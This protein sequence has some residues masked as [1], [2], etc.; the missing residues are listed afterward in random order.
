MNGLRSPLFL[1]LLGYER[2][3]ILIAYHNS[4][5]YSELLVPRYFSFYFLSLKQTRIVSICKVYEHDLQTIPY[6][7]WRVGNG[8]PGTY[9]IDL[10]PWF[11]PSIP[12][13]T[14]R[15]HFVN[16]GVAGVN[17]APPLAT[18]GGGRCPPRTDDAGGDLVQ[19]RHATRRFRAEQN[20]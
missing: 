10:Q 12:S 3:D 13:H 19:I 16:S 2:F 18:L 9:E 7:L 8:I 6:I 14:P 17:A 20:A 11:G 15:I 4:S 5:V 1:T